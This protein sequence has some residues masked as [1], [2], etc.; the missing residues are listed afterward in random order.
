MSLRD[1]VSEIAEDMEREVEPCT[2]VTLHSYAK[3]LR[4]ALKASEGEQ[5]AVI[6]PTPPVTP[7]MQHF[8]AIEAERAKIRSARGESVLGGHPPRDDNWKATA[9]EKAD[10][11]HVEI[12]G[13]Q[14]DGSFVAV[15]P[16]M[17]PG[18]KMPLFGEIYVLSPSPDGPPKLIYSDDETRKYKG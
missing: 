16:E 12:A 9:E 13:G 7:E 6:R 2:T 1:A 18:A 8:L 10:G 15:P 17:P 3:Q 4:R 11:V 14:L 5:P